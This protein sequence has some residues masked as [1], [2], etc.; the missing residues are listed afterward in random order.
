[1]LFA[2][3]E[4]MSPDEVIPKFIDQAGKAQVTEKHLRR[5]YSELIVLWQDTP[6]EDTIFDEVVWEQAQLLI[7]ELI[8]VT[9]V[10]NYSKYRVRVQQNGLGKHMSEKLN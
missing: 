10:Q 5:I 9:S 3:I 8:N 4:L 1:M 6:V 7:D 2:I